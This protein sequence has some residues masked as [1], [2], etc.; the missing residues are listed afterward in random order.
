MPPSYLSIVG[1]TSN[2]FHTEANSKVNLTCK[3][4]PGIPSEYLYWKSGNTTFVNG[5][6]EIEYNFQ[7]KRGDN[8]KVFECIAIHEA[9]IEPLRKTLQLILSGKWWNISVSIH[10]HLFIGV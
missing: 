7:V 9:L 5:S 10:N 6:G 4:I 1:H 2:V 8:L 3:V